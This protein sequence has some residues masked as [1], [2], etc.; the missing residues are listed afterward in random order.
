MAIADTY[1]ELEKFDKAIEYYELAMKDKSV[2]WAAY[3][4]LA[5]C[6]AM[7]KQYPKA[8]KMYFTLY[9][10]DKKNLD[11]QL[12]LAYLYAMEGYLDKSEV[13]YA[14]LWKVN[15]NSPDALINYIDVLIANEKYA[16]ANSFLGFLKE[17]FSD[18]TN[19]T[20]FENKLKDLLPKEEIKLEEDEKNNVLPFDDDKKSDTDKIKDDDKKTSDSN[21]L[22]SDN[23]KDADEENPV[24]DDGAP[25][26][27]DKA[28]DTKNIDEATSD[29]KVQEGT[30]TTKKTKAKKVKKSKK[31]KKSK[32][33]SDAADSTN[34]EEAID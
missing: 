21:S 29:Q 33:T 23:K 15:P 19:I 12:S 28:L 24:L 25:P 9:K 31:S 3:Y 7:N 32:D 10:R 22:T 5:R 4:K 14:Y 26:D 11:I 20:T 18:N 17:R 6:Y 13:I 27:S 16:Q 30:S 1:N 2:Y 34:K 8:R